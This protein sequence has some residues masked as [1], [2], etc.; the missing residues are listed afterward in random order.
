MNHFLTSWVFIGVETG[1]EAA[2]VYGAATVVLFEEA[3][4]IDSYLRAGYAG[5]A[6]AV[7]FLLVGYA[8]AV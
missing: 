4:F 1:V 2:L 6:E 7:E 5:Y 3:G 8:G